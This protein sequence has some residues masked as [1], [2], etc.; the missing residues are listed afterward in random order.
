MMRIGHGYDVHR[1][2]DG[3]DL[4]LGGV[5]TVVALVSGGVLWSC[6]KK[7]EAVSASNEPEAAQELSKAE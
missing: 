5:L 3:R 4:V 2:T 7:M 6:W 1:L